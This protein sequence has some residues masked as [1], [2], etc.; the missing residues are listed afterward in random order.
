M[1]MRYY[2]VLIA[3]VFLPLFTYGQITRNLSLGNTHEEVRTLQQLLNRDPRTAVASTGV[4][5]KGQETTYFGNLTKQAVM[6]FQALYANE[7]LLPAGISNP[8]GFV[9][10]FSQKKLNALSGSIPTSATVSPSVE[11]TSLSQ[12]PVPLP[13]EEPVSSPLMSLFFAVKPKVYALSMYTSKPGEYIEIYGTGFEQKNTVSF[14]QKEVEGLS[15]DGA[16]IRVMVPADL[17]YG[18]YNVSV[19]NS[20]GS[21]YDA[22]FGEYFTVSNSVSKRPEIVSVSPQTLSLSDVQKNIMVTFMSSGKDVSVETS[23]G[24]PS[25]VSKNSNT[26]S[27]SLETVARFSD[28]KAS[29][30]KLETVSFPLAIYIKD[31]H[32]FSENPVMLYIQK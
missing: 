22:S 24:S 32:G 14:S 9:G 1:L 13:Q 15:L 2:F 4:G 27:F 8:T 21:S 26:L 11:P 28:L 30:S 3:L 29:L 7:V 25:V 31:E 23:V 17:S 10:L 18:T 6:R 20:K 12:I 16:T 5:S 19:K